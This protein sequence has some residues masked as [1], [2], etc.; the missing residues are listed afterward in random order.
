MNLTGACRFAAGLFSALT[1]YGADCAPVTLSQ[2]DRMAKVRDLSTALHRPQLRRAA[3][4]RRSGRCARRPALHPKVHACAT[5]WEWRRPRPG[6]FRGALTSSSGRRIV[7]RSQE[8]LCLCRDAGPRQYSCC[9]IL[10]HRQGQPAGCRPV[11]SPNDNRE[12]HA[13]LARFLAENKLFELALAE[14]LRAKR[15]QDTNEAG[16]VELAGLENTVGAYTEAVRNAERIENDATLPQSVRSWQRRVFQSLSYSGAGQQQ[17]AVNGISGT[18]SGSAIRPAETSVSCARRPFLKKAEQFTNAGT[19]PRTGAPRTLIRRQLTVAA[20]ARHAGSGYAR[21]ALRRGPGYSFRDV[22]RQSPDSE[23]AYLNIASACRN[24][25]DPDGELA[26]LRALATIAKAG[27]IR[28]PDPDPD[29][30]G[31]PQLHSC[32]LSS[33]PGRTRESGGDLPHGCGSVLPSRQK[34]MW[35]WSAMPDAVAAFQKAIELRPMET[36]AYYQLGRLYQKLNQPELA[37]EQME[38]GEGP[39]HAFHRAGIRLREL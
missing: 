35:R 19:D 9:G 39:W 11:D 27:T 17:E 36:G 25:S 5:V 7:C 18:P 4:A 13:G 31:T 34:C 6:D 1:A 37:K 22:V 14:S 24:L 29:C 8:L 10:T 3:S 33:D 15:K 28:N 23:E 20:R 26:A 21:A 2:Q 38:R 16:L 30:A 12:L 32:R